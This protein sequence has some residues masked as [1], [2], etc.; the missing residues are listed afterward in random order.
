[1]LKYGSTISRRI[2]NLELNISSEEVDILC[3]EYLSIKQYL[4][5]YQT[6]GDDELRS[7]LSSIF[8]YLISIGGATYLSES[9]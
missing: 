2:H 6:S 5:D 8:G 1:M 9:K 3:E 4:I 7:R